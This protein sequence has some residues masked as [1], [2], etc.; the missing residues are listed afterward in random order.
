MLNFRQ[1]QVLIQELGKPDY[2]ELLQA[3]DYAGIVDVLNA[4]ASVPNPEQQT[5][6]PKRISWSEFITALE[7]ADVVV[8]YSYTW[9]GDLR[10]AI[11]END[12]TIAAAIWRGLTTVITAAS[13][14]A[15]LAKLN[16]T[17]PN[18]DWTP[19]VLEPSI[20]MTLGLPFVTMDDVQSAD[21]QI[22]GR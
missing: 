8:L 1:M 5:N 6:T 15:V 21:Q 16:A 2:S 7:P 4:Q 3:Q 9:V 10:S 19:T 11:T 22:T 20:A 12:R 17:E 13:R 14:T 18:P